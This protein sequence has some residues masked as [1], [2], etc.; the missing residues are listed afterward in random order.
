MAQLRSAVPVVVAGAVVMVRS[1]R[2][3]GRRRAAK[4]AGRRLLTFQPR[5]LQTNGAGSP[6][7]GGGP[8]QTFTG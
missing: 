5:P 2:L 8:S 6:L 3:R 1:G 7:V 4:A